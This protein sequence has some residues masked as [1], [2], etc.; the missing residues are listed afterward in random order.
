MLV[1]ATVFL[2]PSPQARAT[3]AKIN[4]WDH[5]KRKSFCTAKEVISE[6]KWSPTEWEKIFAN[7]ISDKGLIPKLYKDVTQFNFF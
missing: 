7:K 6:M 4:N 5:I 2:D 3:K 1:L